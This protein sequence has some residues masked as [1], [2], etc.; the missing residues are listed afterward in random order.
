MRAAAGTETLY[1]TIGFRE[2]AKEVVGVLETRKPP[3]AEV[4]DKI[5]SACRLYPNHVTLLVAPTASLAG[6]VQIVARS[7]ETALHKLVELKF[8]L[9]R[10]VSAQGTA[11]LPPVAASDLEAIGRTNDAILYDARVI[12]T[13]T[14]DDTSLESIGPQVPSSSSRDYGDPFAAIFTRYN[15]DFYAVDPLLFS[16]AKVV[17]QN[18]ETGRVQAFGQ[19]DPGVLTRSFNY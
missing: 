8:D 9:T 13:V 18:I 1:D 2:S 19:I 12:L 6:G 4:V 5:A 14:G 7:I 3:T 10:V 16:P 17:F 11:P 15:N